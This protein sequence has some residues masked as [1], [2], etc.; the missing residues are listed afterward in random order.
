MGSGAET[1]DNLE[2]SEGAIDARARGETNLLLPRTEA[3][4]YSLTALTAD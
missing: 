2:S 3:G 4:R 1:N